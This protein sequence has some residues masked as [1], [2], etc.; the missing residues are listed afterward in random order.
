MHTLTEPQNQNSSTSISPGM[1]RID[2]MQVYTG[3]LK[4]LIRVVLYSHA[5]FS[6]IYISWLCIISCVLDKVTLF[7]VLDLIESNPKHW[8]SSDWFWPKRQAE[9]SLLDS[10]DRLNL[11]SFPRDSSSFW[12]WFSKKNMATAKASSARSCNLGGIMTL[13]SPIKSSR[14][15]YR[16]VHAQAGRHWKRTRLQSGWV[17]MHGP[18][19]FCVL[20]WI[21]TTVQIISLTQTRYGHA[22]VD[23][24]IC[25]ILE[26]RPP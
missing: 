11:P 18:V 1:Y 14:Q 12:I 6:K 8:W 3:F 26:I 21:F 22:R 23:N 4:T 19:F 5:K 20:A 24:S 9:L 17:C 25:S 13:R 15:R 2:Q 7:S 16:S 10:C